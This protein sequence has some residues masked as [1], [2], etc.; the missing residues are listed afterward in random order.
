MRKALSVLGNVLFVAL[1]LYF[2][3]V[4]IMSCYYWWKDVKAHDSFIRAALWSPVVGMAKAT[5]WP[6]YEFFAR[7]DQKAEPRCIVCLSRSI[8]LYQSAQPLI[9]ALPSSENLARD[10]EAI[11]SLLQRAQTAAEEADRAE[12]NSIAPGF[13]DAVMDKYLQA[14][15]YY[16]A[17]LAGGADKADVSRGDAAMVQFSTWMEENAERLP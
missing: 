5:H 7:R 10:I 15:K 13:G 6:Y 16:N 1:W 17:A 3:S 2:M 8:S 11:T 12:L 4:S 9:Q 14:L